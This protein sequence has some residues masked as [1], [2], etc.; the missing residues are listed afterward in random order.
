M[1]KKSSDLKFCL[2]ATVAFLRARMTEIVLA[3][4]GLL[5]DVYVFFSY[6]PDT[7]STCLKLEIKFLNFVNYCR[8]GVFVVDFE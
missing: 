3:I 4:T 6:C 5:I 7:K 1:E 8:S 2:M